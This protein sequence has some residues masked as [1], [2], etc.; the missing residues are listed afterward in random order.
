MKWRVSKKENLD[1]E[2]DVMWQDLYIENYMLANLKP[3]QKINHFPAMW[4]IFR[5]TFLAK[6]LKRFAKLF[7]LEF[8]FFPQTWILPQEYTELRQYIE[9]CNRAKRAELKKE[10]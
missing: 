7:P 2:F 5:K 10:K 3:Y 6:N 9:K 8:E 1:A 4:N